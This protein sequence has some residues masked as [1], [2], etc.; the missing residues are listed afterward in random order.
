[1]MHDHFGEQK[2]A[3]ELMIAIE[4]L[5]EEGKFLPRDLNGKADTIEVADRVI[6]LITGQNYQPD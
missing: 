4:R 1:M 5:T 3:A 6:D 2:A